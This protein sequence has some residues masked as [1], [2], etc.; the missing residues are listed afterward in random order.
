MAVV[1]Q[2]ERESYL[3]DYKWRISSTDG[4]VTTQKMLDFINK[5]THKN[6]VYKPTQET[7]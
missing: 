4:V 1:S 6:I 7:I 3:K 2:L 5:R